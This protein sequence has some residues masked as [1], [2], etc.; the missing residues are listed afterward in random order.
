M[1]DEEWR[2]FVINELI[3][4]GFTIEYINQY[5]I[6]GGDLTEMLYDV[7]DQIINHRDGEYYAKQIKKFN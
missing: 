4:R 3:K 7:N 1:N 5:E 2:E 6:Y